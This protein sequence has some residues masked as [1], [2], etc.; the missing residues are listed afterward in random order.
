M[1]RKKFKNFILD[2]AMEIIM[3]ILFTMFLLSANFADAGIGHITSKFG[4]AKLCRN[5]GC[6]DFALVKF[7]SIPIELML[8]TD[9]GV[10]SGVAK[11]D[12]GL[13]NF[14][15][16]GQKVMIDPESGQWSGWGWVT[17]VRGGWLKFD[18]KDKNACVKT[19][20]AEV[21]Q[22]EQGLPLLNSLDI[23]KEALS[24]NFIAAPPART[25]LAEE[26]MKPKTILEKTGQTIKK[27]YN[28]TVNMIDSAT[29][30]VLE[31]MRI[32]YESFGGGPAEGGSGL[33]VE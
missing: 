4:Q 13:T 3:I 1:S 10:L 7:A 19:I 29:T 6:S 21:P 23:V 25:T 27:S 31:Q 11:L 9:T 5:V 26:S 15:V 20:W 22:V 30:P 24:K 17:G 28:A 16:T 18:C 8:N 14:S 33:K 12:A 32:I 2:A